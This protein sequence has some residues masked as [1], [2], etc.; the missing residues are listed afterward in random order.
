VR[1]VNDAR[2]GNRLNGRWCA[3]AIDSPVSC[4]QSLTGAE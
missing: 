4:G 3:R 2:L 1:V